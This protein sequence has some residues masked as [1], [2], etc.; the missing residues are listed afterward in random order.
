M[1]I[2]DRDNT[3]REVKFTQKD[4]VTKVYTETREIVNDTTLTEIS[5]QDITGDT[6]L[7]GA[8][9]QIVNSDGKVLDEWISTDKTHTIEGLT[10][11]KEYILR[12]SISPN[13]YVKSTDVKFRVE[14]TK[15]S[16]K[17]KM[18][19]KMVEMTKVDI[20]GKE[21]EGAKMQVFDKDNNLVDE[22]TSTKEP[23]K[24]NNLVENE[25]YKLHEEV[26]IDGYV[27]ATDVEFTVTEDKE[28]QK[29]QMIDKIV[30]VTK[31]DLTNGNEL[32]GAELIV[33]DENDTIIDKWTSTKEAHSISGLEEGK[34]YTLTEKSA[35]YGYETT[36]SI[37]FTVTKDKETQVIEMKDMPILKTIRIIKA[38]SSTKEVI[39]DNF[40][41]GIYE[42]S[43]CAN[44]IKEMKSN[45][46]DG[47]RSCSNCSRSLRGC[48]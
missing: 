27:K 3:K 46:E 4:T 41:F 5:K 20:G 43:E 18:I 17:V 34:T 16:Q 37:T 35:P 11:G 36:E 44:L 13:G 42:D 33:T 26:A 1:C 38:D 48:S 29:L 22:W 30:Q 9:L 47:S 14:N 39:K 21:L 12:E 40:K 32:E 7:V 25:S 6:E 45:K 24:I 8:K 2:R 28:T 19:D 23:H 10:V 31:S 15:D